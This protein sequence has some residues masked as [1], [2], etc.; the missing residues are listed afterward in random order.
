M[1]KYKV[2]YT[3]GVYDMFHI[4]HLNVIKNAHMLC[5]K[6][7]VAVSTDDLVRNEKGIVPIIPF[8]E[9]IQIVQAIRYVDQAVPQISYA[10]EGKIQAAKEYGIDV[11]FVGSDW[12]G[13]KKWDTIEHQLSEL[14]V[15][16][17][18][19]PHTDGISST[20]LRKLCDQ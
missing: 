8:S 12:K 18:Y 17:V 7:V 16:V 6:L 20:M 3:A 9:R 11:M 2:G 10:A 15:D 4:G 5:E 14:G 19:L 13:S 1:K